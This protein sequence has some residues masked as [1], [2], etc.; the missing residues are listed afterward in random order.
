MNLVNNVRVRR[1][2]KPSSF[3]YPLLLRSL[4]LDVRLFVEVGEQEVEH[5]GMQADAPHKGP[6]EVALHKQQLE[7]MDHHEDEL[8]LEKHTK[9]CQIEDDLVRF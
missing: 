7:G 9:K 4:L 8:N 2:S 5:D 1:I 3:S 6:W